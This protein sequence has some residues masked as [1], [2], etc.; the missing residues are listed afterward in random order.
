[1]IYSKQ[2]LINGIAKEFHILKHLSTKVT[3]E[4]VDHK[5]SEPQRDVKELMIYLGYAL[6]RQII[7][8]VKGEWD[9]A[10]FADMADLSSNFDRKTWDA[11]LDKS[12]AKITTIIE[13]MTDEQ[14]NESI[15]MFG[16]S[17]PRFEYIAN[18]ILT[19]LG[20]YKM[21]LF[22]QLKA[23]GLTDLNSMNLWA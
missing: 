15:T 22:L 7:N 13:G 2:S 10:T 14:C 11:V 6:E 9:T 21:Q 19:T 20:A 1:M 5:F 23:A 16:S 3:H 4:N 18:N 12:L 17:A 8:F